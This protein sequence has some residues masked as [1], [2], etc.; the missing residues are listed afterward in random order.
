MKL[1]APGGFLSKIIMTLCK[2]EAQ[3]DNSNLP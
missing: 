2:E 3:L 1:N